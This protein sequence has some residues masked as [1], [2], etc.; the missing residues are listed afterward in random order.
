MSKDCSVL[1]IYVELHNLFKD[2]HFSESGYLSD[3]KKDRLDEL[4]ERWCES[5][6][7]DVCG[8][9]CLYM[10]E[11]DQWITSLNHISLYDLLDYYCSNEFPPSGK[12]ESRVG[13]EITG[14]P[15]GRLPGSYGSNQ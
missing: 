3:K 15:A 1:D 5:D 10:T 13:G 11:Q 9:E 6:C 12:L 14:N 8:N 2:W 7:S 4:L